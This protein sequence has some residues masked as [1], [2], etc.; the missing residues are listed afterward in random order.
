ME[1]HAP[2]LVFDG[3][4]RS[5]EIDA[6]QWWDTRVVP[7]EQVIALRCQRPHLTVFPAH[8]LTLAVVID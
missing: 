4:T 3:T 7:L 1:P 2:F 5:R 8:H 6:G